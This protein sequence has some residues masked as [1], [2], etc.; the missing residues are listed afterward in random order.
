MLFPYFVYIV[1]FAKFTRGSS[2]LTESLLM[3]K[4]KAE[5]SPWWKRKKYRP[6]EER[7]STIL[8]R[9]EK[10]PSWKRLAVAELHAGVQIS[11]KEVAVKTKF[12]IHNVKNEVSFP[13]CMP[14]YKNMNNRLE[15]NFESCRS[16]CCLAPQH[17]FRFFHFRRGFFLCLW[18]LCSLLCRPPQRSTERSR[19]KKNK[20]QKKNKKTCLQRSTC[21]N[22]HPANPMGER[23]IQVRL[24]YFSSRLR[25][26]STAARP[27]HFTAF[28]TLRCCL[29][30]PL[31]IPFKH[32]AESN[33]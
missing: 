19:L 6:K 16:I 10:N 17:I 20:K 3:E 31:Y 29:M 22:S 23:L 8:A 2:L 15:C 21:V 4:S 9:K 25:C 7:K 33:F 30:L 28:R 5:E 1:H 27:Q 14:C 24:Y 11:N 12:A 18:Q 26:W 13:F 32:N